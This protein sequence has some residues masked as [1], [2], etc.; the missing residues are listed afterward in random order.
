MPEYYHLPVRFSEEE[1]EKYAAWGIKKAKVK[2]PFTVLFLVLDV[3]AC[4]G[5]VHFFIRTDSVEEFLAFGIVLL[6]LSFLFIKPL[7]RLCDKI[8]KKPQEP[9]MLRL[10]P[11]VDGMQYELFRQKKLLRWGVLPWDV[12]DKAISTQTNQ[13]W[14]PGEWLW[15]GRNTIETIYP[16][17]KRHKWMEKPTEKIVGT[18]KLEEIQK[19]M[20]GYRASLEEQKREEEWRR[21]SE[22]DMCR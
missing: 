6:G 12:W 8:C 1:R 11:S 4:G 20:K 22:H 17:G 9:R 7:D 16:L 13:I 18:I 5:M 2:P 15:I 14:I 19:L 21:Q 10:E 3:I